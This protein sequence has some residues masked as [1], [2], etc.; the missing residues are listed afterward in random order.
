LFEI[1]GHT[2]YAFNP[3][4]TGFLD[5]IGLWAAEDGGSGKYLGTEIDAKVAY[6]P[7]PNIVMN[8]YFGYFITGNWFD[9]AAGAR[10][11]GTSNVTDNGVVFRAE[12]IV[13]F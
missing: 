8:G 4:V 13:T 5:V 3:K 7:Y 6:K 10:P 1:K 9:S 11:A 2:Q 12:A